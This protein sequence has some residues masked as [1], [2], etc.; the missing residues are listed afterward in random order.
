MIKVSVIGATGYTGIELLRLLRQHKEVEVK[1]LVS[2]SNPGKRLKDIYPQ[3]PDDNNLLSKYNIEELKESDLVFT[4]LPHGVS[5]DYVS[6]LYNNEIRVIDF[7]GDYRYRDVSI[8]ENWYGIEHKYPE[9]AREAVYG[10]VELNREMLREAR[11]V[12][13]P[14][15]YPTASL[16]GLL[17]LLKKG[18][19]DEE[20]IVIDAKSGVS[21]AGK[22][23]KEAFI[24]NE[25][26]SSIKAYGINS[27]RHTS[28]IE[29]VIADLFKKSII[30][31]TPH[32]I[33][34]KRGIL[35]TIYTKLREKIE[36]QDLIKIYKQ[37]YP[38]GGFVK[39]L[40]EGVPETKYVAGSNY[41]YLTLKI[42]KRT[43][44]LVIISAIDNLLKGASGQAV[45]AMNVMFGLPEKTG[46]K[47]TA[48][49][50]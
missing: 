33:P 19:L 6:E 26:A 37:F 3:F 46:L 28:E 44:R 9:I 35:A 39:I 1:K 42:D 11:L 32:L 50:P 40:T 21:G 36:I 29:A 23:V 43:G 27:H 47:G 5:Q 13:N 14:G 8:Y 34:V 45:Q 2:R 38:E 31:F 41:C 4:A 30:S 15:C 22:A 18:L 16:L 48:L 49:F 20:F 25:V 17:P 7:S 24:F 12:A 10:L